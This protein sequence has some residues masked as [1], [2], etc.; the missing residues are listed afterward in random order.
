MTT[1]TWA[2]T[3]VAGA[4]FAVA[5]AGLV[6]DVSGAARL[7]RPGDA[8]PA[9]LREAV[10]VPLLPP[11]TADPDALPTVPVPTLG[12]G[13]HLLAPEVLL[14]RGRARSPALEETLT[15]LVAAGTPHPVAAAWG[16]D[17]GGVVVYGGDRPR[18]TSTVTVE[19][20]VASLNR[21]AGGIAGRP[22][23]VA[24]GSLGG[25][26]GCGR[27][28]VAGGPAEGSYCVWLDADVFAFLLQAGRSDTADLVLDVRA[29]LER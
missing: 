12:P 7:T 22:A 16:T 28:Q 29:A 21:G 1:P 14:G 15:G 9:V 6:V 25:E 17:A 5:A 3:A 10:T 26:V 2:A 18:T 24:A 8:A 19:S 4:A 11:A 27:L 20:L 23:P 13:R